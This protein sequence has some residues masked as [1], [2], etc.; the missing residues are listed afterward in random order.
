MLFDTGYL[1]F[2]TRHTI[3]KESE[4]TSIIVCQQSDSPA[5][6][7][8]RRRNPVC[9]RLSASPLVP[10]NIIIIIINSLLY[11]KENSNE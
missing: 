2:Y 6:G 5:G 8:P 4:A 7:I 11:T 1:T 10:R 3:L 9:A